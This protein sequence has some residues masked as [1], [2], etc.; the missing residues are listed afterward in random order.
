MQRDISTRVAA[1]KRGHIPQGCVLAPK[2]MVDVATR[3][4]VEV[5]HATRHR[6]RLVSRAPR[7]LAIVSALPVTTHVRPQ[8]P[9]GAERVYQRVCACHRA[10]RATR[11]GWWQTG[12]KQLAFRFDGTLRTQ[13]GLVVAARCTARGAPPVST[14]QLYHRPE[15]Y[16]FAPRRSRVWPYMSYLQYNS[17]YGS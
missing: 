13:T 12:R 4:S 8:R 11:D 17:Q 6:E 9:V 14:I 10:R 16:T 1:T 2:L 5:A 15:Y 7:R 3:Q